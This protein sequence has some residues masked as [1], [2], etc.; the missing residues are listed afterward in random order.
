MCMSNGKIRFCSRIQPRKVHYIGTTIVL[1]E[2]ASGTR[3]A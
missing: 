2:A 3:K 1:Y